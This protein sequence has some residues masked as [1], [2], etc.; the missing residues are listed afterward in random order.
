MLYGVADFWIFNRFSSFKCFILVRDFFFSK[1]II[2]FQYNLGILIHFVIATMSARS[3]RSHQTS[4]SSTPST[5]RV[6]PVASS[7]TASADRRRQ[8]SAS[9]LNISRNEEKEEL[10]E[11]N[12]RLA[13]YIDYVRKLETDKEHLK[14]QMRIFTEERLVRMLAVTSCITPF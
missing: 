9:P 13:S 8:R 3:K 7:S 12:D 5:K 4:D 14:R 11:L 10:A 1:W 2:Y 6:T